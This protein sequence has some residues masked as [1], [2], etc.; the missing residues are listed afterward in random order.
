MNPELE[1]LKVKLK[2]SSG[3]KFFNNLEQYTECVIP[4]NLKNILKL[5]GYN[6]A[7]SLCTFDD[8][9]INEIEDFM[10]NHFTDDMLDN[11]ETIDYFGCFN[12]IRSKFV[13][14]GGQKRFIFK[15]IETC[16]SLYEGGIFNDGSSCEVPMQGSF[17]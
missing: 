8:N 15:L 13:I 6:T 16:R 11:G 3:N 14:V 4:L 17:K 5:N 12:K 10:R 1:L 2:N 7:S 9:S